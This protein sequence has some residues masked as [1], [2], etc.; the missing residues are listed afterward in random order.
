MALRTFRRA[1]S[2]SIVHQPLFLRGQYPCQ[3]FRYV[4]DLLQ[5]T[6]SDGWTTTRISSSSCCGWRQ[7][8]KDPHLLLFLLRMETMEQR[9]TTRSNAKQRKVFLLVCCSRC[10]RAL[11]PAPFTGRPSAQF[12]PKHGPFVPSRSDTNSVV[13][14]LRHPI[15]TILCPSS[16][17]L[18][19][20]C[21]LDSGLGRCQNQNGRNQLAGD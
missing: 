18:Y 14:I 11:L 15:Y 19:F 20:A 12:P 13:L 4:L 6:W 21:E 2:S 8:N 1:P 10:S 7:W 9:P 16:L 5:H 3:T 17:D